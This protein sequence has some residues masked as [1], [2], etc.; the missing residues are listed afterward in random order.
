MQ[1]VRI[2][3]LS[4]L[5]QAHAAMADDFADHAGAAYTIKP[6]IVY[7]TASN[8]PLTLDVYL[9]AAGK[10]PVLVYFHGGGWVEGRKENAALLLMPY[11]ALGWAVVN[12]EY[13]LAK[14]ASA[15]AAVEDVRCALRW[16]HERAGE[17]K[18]D[19]DAVVVAGDSAGGHLALMAAM[20]PPG[21]EYDRRCPTGDAYR[22]GGAAEPPMKVA[23]VVNWFGVTDVA[24]M[25]SGPG[26]RHFAIEWFGADAG[27]EA[28]ARRLSPINNI[29][30]G[31]PPVITVHGNA[32]PVVPY[33][34]AQSLHA[35][36]DGAK[37]INK[38]ISIEGGRHG[39]FAKADMI[40][41]NRQIRAFLGAVGLPVDAVR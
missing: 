6:N 22:W 5:L 1:V 18:F 11:L 7:A 12:V 39:G 35:A 4:L 9:P 3:L 27:R 23:A 15:P 40:G 28:L 37:V 20:L 24:A 33:A 26:A 16:V 10:R 2:I 30:Q 41:A 29:R 14:V 32:D 13:R 17:Y 8:V 19:L 36:L 21:N 38:L 34:Q 31:I 25:L